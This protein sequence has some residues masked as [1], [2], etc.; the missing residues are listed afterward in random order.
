MLDLTSHFL[1]LDYFFY[2]TT[3]SKGHLTQNCIK[4]K[5]KTLW[6]SNNY[7]KYALN[8]TTVLQNVCFI[9]Q[10]ILHTIFKAHFGIIVGHL[11]ICALICILYAL[12]TTKVAQVCC[13]SQS[14]DIICVHRCQSPQVISSSSSALSLASSGSHSLPHP[15]NITMATAQEWDLELPYY[16]PLKGINNSQSI[17]H[18]PRKTGW[19][20]PSVTI[21]ND[22]SD[23][24]F[25]QIEICSLI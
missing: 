3:K 7:I 23:Q 14:N 6:C 2:W 20:E 16:R 18:R 21:N 9:Q 19:D 15:Q 13:W 5:M 4:N 11:G 12:C 8:E 24:T 25:N 17:Q 22:W 10:T 1:F